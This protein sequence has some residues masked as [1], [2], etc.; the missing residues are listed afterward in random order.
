VPPE[1]TEGLSEDVEDKAHESI[2]GATR[3]WLSL[4]GLRPPP[5]NS[6]TEAENGRRLIE[7][8]QNHFDKY[9]S[10]IIL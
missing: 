8:E 2:I 5:E 4:C 3:L 10:W 7:Q 9:A 6:G 1:C